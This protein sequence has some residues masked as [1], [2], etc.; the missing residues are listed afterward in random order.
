MDKIDKLI[1]IR[2]KNF[3]QSRDI[4]LKNQ[5]KELGKIFTTHITGKTSYLIHIHV[6][7]WIYPEV[8]PDK[9]I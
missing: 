5:D 8:D 6:F 9:R 1:Y 2:N 7:V 3:C 4:K